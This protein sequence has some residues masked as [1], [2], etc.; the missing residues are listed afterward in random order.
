MV[1]NT[2]EVEDKK[3]KPFIID[4]A[5]VLIVVPLVQ[6]DINGGTIFSPSIHLIFMAFSRKIFAGVALLYLTANTQEV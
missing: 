1:E 4:D 5:L 2:M 3:P 6:S